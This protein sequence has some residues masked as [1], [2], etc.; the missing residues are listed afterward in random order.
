ME[1]ME[2]KKTKVMYFAELRE[3]VVNYVTDV[4][5]QD[6]LLEFIDKEVAAIER[7]KDKAR[8]RA[9]KRK[10]ESDALTDRIY[11][12]LHYDYITVN[13][14]L[15]QLEDE[16]DISAGKITSRLGKLVRAGKI[17]KERIKVREDG[18]RKMGYRKVEEIAA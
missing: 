6:E 15:E 1:T 5:E 8:E 9:E 13:D 3:M 11:D 10:A 14:I 2:T 18:T 7:R 4:V 16:E 12:I 17:E